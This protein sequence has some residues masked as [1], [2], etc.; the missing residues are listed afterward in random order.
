[1]AGAPPAAR[2]AILLALRRHPRCAIRV[3][4][5]SRL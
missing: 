5:E 2:D 1:V 3:F 4:A